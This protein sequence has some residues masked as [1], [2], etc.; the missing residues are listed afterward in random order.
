MTF[1]A[2]AMGIGIWSMHYI[3]MLAFSL[4]I[5]VFYDL[6]TV[7][8]SLLAAIF[9]SAIALYVVSRERLGFLHLAVGSLVMGGGIFAMHYVGMAA[10]R[11]SAHC[12]YNPVIVALSGVIAILVSGAA[13]WITF[14]MRQ[15]GSKLRW[16]RAAAAVVMGLAIA[17]MHYTGMAAVCFRH[18]HVPPALGSAISIS[19]LGILGISLATCFIL[20][21]AIGMSVADRYISLQN[22]TLSVTKTEY[23][24]FKQHSLL[25]VS[26]TSLDG[27]FLEVND[28][29]LQ[30]L[31]YARR[32]D[33]LGLNVSD[34]YWYPEDRHRLMDALRKDGAVNGLEMCM[35]RTDG[36]PIWIISNLALTISINGEAVEVIANSM[37]ISAT[38]KNQE[39][40][41]LA[42]EQAE[43]ANRAKG[44]FLANMS[45]EL[46]TPL[47]GILGMTTLALQCDLPDDV[48]EY[49]E[50]SKMSA[51]AL[52]HIINNVLDFSKIDAQ[53]LELDFRHFNLKRVLQDAIR[54]VAVSADQK[55]IKLTL[56]L[57]D[58]LPEFVTGDSGRLRQVFLNLL[59]N[60]IKFTD[61]G[62]VTLVA[63]GSATAP[64][65]F[66]LQVAVRDTGIGIS[67]GNLDLIFEAFA[68]AD[69]S[70]T[71]RF[72]G[73]GLGLAISSQLIR[74]M[75]GTIRVE[76][77]VGQ[78]SAFHIEVDLGLSS[79]SE[80]LEGVSTVLMQVS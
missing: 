44:H 47:N 68:Q 16:L 14:R 19:A 3:G 65:Q 32:E 80:E 31:G 26:R 36:N 24:L 46:R 70:S 51:D 12:V 53:K 37:D 58:S 29:V 8:L 9:A 5:P 71:R 15:D 45:H 34:H 21:L 11:L 39:D 49:L 48:R 75:G 6:P 2:A 13:L 52:I 35:K 4:N 78:G 40:L 33:I 61:Q 18:V 66:R 50:D 59:G 60:A 76:S 57:D 69:L 67:A 23:D 62:E 74:A 10:M 7:A 77:T 42:K 30:T 55:K 27:R 72:G 38:K 1:G 28:A 25:C 64:N 73:T 56:D 54:T 20:L 41:R 17:T 63:R 79:G 22:K 43:A